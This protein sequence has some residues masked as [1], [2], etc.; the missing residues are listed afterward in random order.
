MK[1]LL[2]KITAW[3]FLII[4]FVVGLAFIVLIFLLPFLIEEAKL[5]KLILFDIFLFL[6]GCVII[7]VGFGI[8]EFFLSLIDI[9][10]ELAEIESEIEQKG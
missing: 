8:Y 5:S 6:V 2:I 4:S 3:I 10:K 7:V 1:N 9:E